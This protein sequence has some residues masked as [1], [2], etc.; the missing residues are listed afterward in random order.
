MLFGSIG[1]VLFVIMYCGLVVVCLFDFKGKW[2]VFG[3]EGSGVCELS[4]VLLK[5]NG[6][7]LGG[8]IELLLIVGEDVVIVLFDGKIDVVF[9]FGDLM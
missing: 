5:M 3:V 7:V 1:Y 2:F 9:L 6:I 4:F 8:L